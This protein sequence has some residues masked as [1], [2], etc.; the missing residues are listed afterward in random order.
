[1]E[2]RHSV[3]QSRFRFSLFGLTGFVLVAAMS[4]APLSGGVNAVGEASQMAAVGI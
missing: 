2:T 4:L 1:M 3:S